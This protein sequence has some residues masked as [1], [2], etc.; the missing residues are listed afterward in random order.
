MT[1]KILCLLL[2]L[3][4]VICAQTITGVSGT[5]ED[6]ESITITGSGFGATGTPGPMGW[7]K[8]DNGSDGEVI[9]YAGNDSNW[10]GYNGANTTVYSWCLAGQYGAGGDLTLPDDLPSGMDQ[11]VFFPTY[12]DSF[13][14]IAGSL[15]LR[16]E[17]W[18][19]DVYSIDCD[20]CGNSWGRPGENAASIFFQG[21]N[22]VNENFYASFW[23]RCSSK[24]DMDQSA[25][26]DRY[27]RNMKIISRGRPDLNRC[28]YWEMS[29][30]AQARTD[31]ASISPACS[32][33]VQTP[34]N[35][36]DWGAPRL[37]D[38]GAWNRIEFFIDEGSIY[39]R[40]TIFMWK[41]GAGT[42]AMNTNGD[43]GPLSDNQ[44]GDGCIGGKLKLGYYHTWNTD[45]LGTQMWRA[46][47]FDDVYVDSTQARVELGNDVSFDDCTHREIQIPTS[48]GD[49]SIGA[50][51]NAGTFVADDEVYL[52]VVDREG[53]V[54]GGYELTMGGEGPPG[55]GTIAPCDS[56]WV[57]DG[58]G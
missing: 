28:G 20:T 17:Y 32:D 36:N 15:S 16:R 14:R 33:S 42:G 31:K 26:S 11:E 54:S 4:S 7:N 58:G 19:E 30:G 18:H 21:M 57:E 29:G 35:V 39:G 27:I 5:I 52:F 46:I 56:V 37:P 3:P 13:A 55:G 43:G 48:W 53:N 51:I 38:A 1:S 2:L 9:G 10:V 49:T 41:D 50:T 44:S 22:G 8:F 24:A 47:Y 6:G 40:E 23:I 45:D 25:N 12:S 34:P